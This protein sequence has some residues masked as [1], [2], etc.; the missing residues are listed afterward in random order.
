MSNFI[1]IVIMVTDE[2][3]DITLVHLYQGFNCCDICIALTE[4][5]LHACS[6]YVFVLISTRHEDCSESNASYF[7]M[8]AHNVRGG[9][10]W[11]G[12]ID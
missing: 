12:S 10:W 4:R 7:I 1:K 3:N 8:L 9:C 5:A 6:I 2:I 11:Y